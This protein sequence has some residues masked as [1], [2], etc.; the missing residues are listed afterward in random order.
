MKT[1]KLFAITV[2]CLVTILCV[3]VFADPTAY[4][5]LEGYK[6]DVGTPV[7]GVVASVGTS[8]ENPW[9][10]DKYP[11]SYLDGWNH[12]PRVN[13]SWY[14]LWTAGGH[15]TTGT[16]AAGWNSL[17]NSLA[18]N[19]AFDFQG[20][21]LLRNSYQ[22]DS[23]DP[24]YGYEER[25]YKRMDTAGEGVWEIFDVAAGTSIA[26]GTLGEFLY[27]DIFYDLLNNGAGASINT[28]GSLVAEDDG[29]AFYAELIS[30]WGTPVLNMTI[31]TNDPPIL[32]E[33]PGAPLDQGW[34]IYGIEMTISPR[35]IVNLEEFA[36]LS[37][38]WKM[39][40]CDNG[41][42]CNE[43]DWYNDGTIDLL[44]LRQLAISWLSTGIVYDHP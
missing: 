30:R 10:A 17:N 15:A 14:G 27:M 40:G 26:S 5:I 23:N 37:K 13:T 7:G 19:Y 35:G 36:L 11:Y 39:S 34:A 9:L 32:E 12:P 29:G 20:Y 31:V 25:V 6:S 42:P 1:T 33:N 28:S 16:N 4:L 38:Y 44:D 22:T 8:P 3:T 24:K 21:E 2:I 41:Q 18:G 43:A